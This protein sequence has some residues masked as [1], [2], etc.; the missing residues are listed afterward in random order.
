MISLIFG[1]SSHN[2]HNSLCIYRINYV[3]RI[4]LRFLSHAN[5][6]DGEWKAKRRKAIYSHKISIFCIVDEIDF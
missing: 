3:L 2:F 4:F 1:G 6:T 5:R